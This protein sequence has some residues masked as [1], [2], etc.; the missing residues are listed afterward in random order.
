MNLILG[1]E[2]QEPGQAGR[3]GQ[4][5]RW[6]ARSRVPSARCEAPILS[7]GIGT[8]ILFVFTLL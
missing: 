6:P 1:Y 3:A 2:P 5:R 4:N 8:R 7:V